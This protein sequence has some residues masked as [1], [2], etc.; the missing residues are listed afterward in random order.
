MNYLQLLS[1]SVVEIIKKKF[2]YKYIFETKII[3]FL[4]K[5]DT[6]IA[7]NMRFKYYFWKEKNTDFNLCRSCFIGN[8]FINR[9]L[10]IAF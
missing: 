9:H 3:N 5:C 8:I 2:N 4:I 6:I 1:L 10:F 7:I